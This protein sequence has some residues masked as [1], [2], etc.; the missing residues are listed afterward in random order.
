MSARVY[1]KYR[2]VRILDDADVSPEL[3]LFAWRKRDKVQEYMDR[4]EAGPT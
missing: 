3:W 2:M 4:E 1:S